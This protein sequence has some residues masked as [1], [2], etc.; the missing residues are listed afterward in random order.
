[1]KNLIIITFFISILGC[2]SQKEKDILFIKEDLLKNFNDNAF[3]ENGKLNINSFE[4][5]KIDTFRRGLIDSF[6]INRINDAKFNEIEGILKIKSDNAKNSLDLL[7]LSVLADNTIMKDK[8]RKETKEFADEI[9]SYT[10]SLKEIIK[11]KEKLLTNISKNN[12]KEI[13][14]EVKTFFKGTYFLGK[15]STNILDTIRFYYTKDLKRLKDEDY[16]WKK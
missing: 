9:N 2:K 6:I 8:Y 7:Q 4:I 10:D 12:N 5:L 1:M 14:Y 16:R 15:D 13:G 11:F 3:K